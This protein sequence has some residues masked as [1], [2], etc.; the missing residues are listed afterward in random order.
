ML[1]QAL[2]AVQLGAEGS[3]LPI[4]RQQHR[5]N[6]IRGRR[7]G[8]FWESGSY[9]WHEG[10]G[11]RVGEKLQRRGTRSDQ[12]TRVSR[13]TPP[14]LRGLKEKTFLLLPPCPPSVCLPAWFIEA[15]LAPGGMGAAKCLTNK[16]DDSGKSIRRE[17]S[18][19]G[20]WVAT[21]SGSRRRCSP[22]CVGGNL[23]PGHLYPTTTS[24][25]S[26]RS[27]R[28][29]NPT[30]TGSDRGMAFGPLGALDQCDLGG[31]FSGHAATAGGGASSVGSGRSRTHAG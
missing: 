3:F 22:C 10:C 12:A 15:P 19:E 23:H 7:G 30:D 17:R 2:A 21:A 14:T 11:E 6:T 27:N 8:S 5:W 26:A 29:R 16:H 18:G 1:H 28:P 25:G 13:Y 31:L 9:R 4:Q 20:S 24:G